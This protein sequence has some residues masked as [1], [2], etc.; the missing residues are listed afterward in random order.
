MS[1][2]SGLNTAASGLAAARR[3]M[4]VVGQKHRQPEDRG[5]HASAGPDLGHRGDRPDRPIQRRRSAGTRRLDR[6]RRPSRRCP[7]RRP[8][9]RLARRI[10]LLVH[11]RG[12]RDHD[13]GLAR[14]AHRE[15]TG[16]ATVEV[17]V[18]L[19]RSRKHTGLRCSGIHHP[20]IRQGA[21]VPHRRRLP[22]RGHPVERRAGHRRAHRHAG[23]CRRRPDRGAQRR[24]PR[25][26]RL[27]ALGERAHGPAE[28]AR[29]ERRPHVRGGGHHRER[30]VDDPPRRRQR[31]GLGFRCAPTSSST[32][33][34]RS[35]RAALHRLVGIRPRSPGLDRR[36]RARRLA[37]RARTGSRRRHCSRSSPRPT[38]RWRQPW[39]VR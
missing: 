17:L 39:P 20:R 3:G 35:T 18:R 15:R 12:R 9:P 19:A 29:T 2:F 33:R 7:A 27:R 22:H 4:D 37:R 38:T 25:R 21:R 10:G 30:R 31:A 8:R 24:D 28:R 6:R 26:P 11:A 23:Q 1:T 36:R 16:G 14:R 34:P 5:L 13:R 32:A